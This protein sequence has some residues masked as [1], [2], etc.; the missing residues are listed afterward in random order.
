[1]IKTLSDLV[2]HPHFLEQDLD[3]REKAIRRFADLSG[4]DEDKADSLV[5]DYERRFLAV[6]GDDLQK[7]VNS[8]LINLEDRLSK[9]LINK[10]QY[11][12][13]RS[14]V[15]QIQK[16]GL[17]SRQQES[18]ALT[19]AGRVAEKFSFGD[20]DG[21]VEDVFGL[22]REVKN[23]VFSDESGTEQINIL[24]NEYS[25]LRKQRGLTHKDALDEISQ[26]K[27]AIRQTFDG[28]AVLLPDNQVV[29]KEDL[30]LQDKS[31]VK[32]ALAKS[33]IPKGRQ[34]LFLRDEFDS[35]QQQRAEQY[36]EALKSFFDQTNQLDRLPSVKETDLGYV[37]R[38]IEE[39]KSE[40]VVGGTIKRSG[41][42]LTNAA[43]SVITG[44]TSGSLLATGNEEKAREIS[45]ETSKSLLARTILSG[46]N[47]GSQLVADAI[48][49]LVYVLPA[50]KGAQVGGRAL[51]ALGGSAKLGARTG[52][53]VAAGLTGTAAD[54]PSALTT[55]GLS[56]KDA[57][58]SSIKSG[59]IEAIASFAGGGAGV[60][61]FLSREF[62]DTLATTVRKDLVRFGVD[63]SE[64]ALEEG[65]TEAAQFMFVE[66]ER[67]PNATTADL[68]EAAEKGA[69]IGSF[70]GAGS[71]AVSIGADKLSPAPKP[72]ES[73][74]ITD[75]TSDASLN[76]LKEQ[77]DANL[78]QKITNRN[79]QSD[80]LKTK[81]ED[82]PP[83]I[84][85]DDVAA[86]KGE[87]TDPETPSSSTP[88]GEGTLEEGSG[89]PV[90]EVTPAEPASTP[91]QT[92]PKDVEKEVLKVEETPVSSQETKADPVVEPESIP[93]EAE[94]TSKVDNAPVVEET[95]SPTDSKVT[96]DDGTNTPQVVTEESKVTPSPELPSNPASGEDGLTQGT[97]NPPFEGSTPSSRSE[98]TTAADIAR[99]AQSQPRG[100][101]DDLLDAV[102]AKNSPKAKQAP[103][104]PEQLKEQIAKRKQERDPQPDPLPD[105]VGDALDVVAEE[106]DAAVEG[107]TLTKD[108]AN[109]L[110]SLLNKV[111]T[112]AQA[113]KIRDAIKNDNFDLPAAKE[114]KGKS[115]KNA[116]D[117]FKDNIIND[118]G[119]GNALKADTLSSQQQIEVINEAVNESIGQE[120]ADQARGVI[121]S[122]LFPQVEMTLEKQGDRSELDSAEVSNLA[123]ARTLNLVH[124]KMKSGMTF[125]E[126][127]DSAIFSNG[128]TDD[129]SG[130]RD[131]IIKNAIKTIRRE[132]QKN[133][134]FKDSLQFDQSRQSRKSLFTKKG[135]R[136]K[137]NI[138]SE[139]KRT[140]F[141]TSG[142]EQHVLL[143]SPRGTQVEVVEPTNRLLKNMVDVI[144]DKT[145]AEV[146]FFA[147]NNPSEDDGFFIPN[148]NKVYIDINSQR[149]TALVVGHEVAHMLEVEK[150]EIFNTLVDSLA[151]SGVL[152]IGSPKYK[153]FLKRR[154]YQTDIHSAEFF[155]EYTSDML[156][157]AFED[158][159][160]LGELRSDINNDSV[161]QQ[162]IEA[163][164]VVFNKMLI[165]MRDV[166]ADLLPNSDENMFSAFN[167]SL[168]AAYT[169]SSVLNAGAFHSNPV[170]FRMQTVH[171]NHFRLVSQQM[172]AE[173]FAAPQANAFMELTQGDVR[174]SRKDNDEAHRKAEAAGDL[175]TGQELV[176]EA[177]KKSGYG[178][179]HRQRNPDFK[180]KKE[181]AQFVNGEEVS[182]SYGDYQFVT[183][184]LTEIPEWL[185]QMS[186][187]YF[188]DR[189]QV[190]PTDIVDAALAWDD[191]QFAS[192]VWQE[193]ENRGLAGEVVG[194]ETED[195]GVILDP[196]TAIED[197]TVKSADPFTYDDN[198]VLIPLSER[199]NP[200]SPDIR[201]SKKSKRIT[202]NQGAK[203][204]AGAFVAE[205]GPLRD[206]AA[207]VIGK[208]FGSEIQD[209]SSEELIRKVIKTFMGS[210]PEKIERNN[211]LI[212]EMK[213]SYKGEFDINTAEDAESLVATA[214]KFYMLGELPNIQDS[215]K[216][217]EL[218]GTIARS[219]I[220][221]KTPEK[222]TTLNRKIRSHAQG[223]S[224]T[225]NIGAD[226]AG[227]GWRYLAKLTDTILSAHKI[228]NQR[229]LGKDADKIKEELEGNSNEEVY[230]LM[231]E[232]SEQSALI[233]RSVES[234]KKQRRDNNRVVENL[235]AMLERMRGVVERSKKKQTQQEKNN[236]V[237]DEMIG[238]LRRVAKLTE[239]T[240]SNDIEFLLKEADEVSAIMETINFDEIQPIG[241]V[242]DAVTKVRKATQKNKEITEEVHDETDG[243]LEADDGDY[244]LTKKI[245]NLG[246]SIKNAKLNR[247]INAH[248][249]VYNTE[250]TRLRNGEVNIEGAIS[251]LQSTQEFS[252]ADVDKIRS[253]LETDIELRRVLKESIDEASDTKKIHERKL[254]QMRRRR[255]KGD[256]KLG[257]S[258]EDSLK[259]LISGEI[260]IDQAVAEIQQD[261][262]DALVNSIEDFL[263]EGIESA[264]ISEERKQER[265]KVIAER[266]KKRQAQV[267]RSNYIK[268]LLTRNR[269]T[270]EQFDKFLS[271]L[272]KLSDTERF[273]LQSFRDKLVEARSVDI[274]KEDLEA[275]KMSQEDY[276]KMVG[277]LQNVT[278]RER[279]GLF[280]FANDLVAEKAKEDA[281]LEALETELERKR[282][283]D[284][285]E[286]MKDLL[287]RNKFLPEKFL[288]M[289][290]KFDQLSPK[291][292]TELINFL[293][294]QA[295]SESIDVMKGLYETGNMTK[296]EF[297]KSVATL[298]TVTPAKRKTLFNFANKVEEK[299]AREEQ[300]IQDEKDTAERKAQNKRATRLKTLLTTG[301]IDEKFFADRVTE[302]DKLSDKEKSQLDTFLKKFEE[303]K[304]IDD[305]KA[306]LEGGEV[307]VREFKQQVNA[308]KS[309]TDKQRQALLDFADRA[310]NKA[311]ASLDSNLGEKFGSPMT[312][313]K[314]A[315]S[316]GVGA[317]ATQTLRAKTW[318]DMSP[319]EKVKALKG[320]K[321]LPASA[322][323]TPILQ[324][325]RDQLDIINNDVDSVRDGESDVMTEAIQTINTLVKESKVPPSV[326]LNNWLINRMREDPTFW[327][328]LPSRKIEVIREWIEQDLKNPAAAQIFAELSANGITD[329]SLNRIAEGA[330]ARFDK[331]ARQ[332]A[333]SRA[334]NLSNEL[335]KGKISLTT[336]MDG[337]YTGII[338]HTVS[339][340]AVI[341]KMLGN[342]FQISAK[343]LD[344]ITKNNA[345]VEK[346]IQE[347]LDPYTL[348]TGK[349]ALREIENVLTRELKGYG[350]SFARTIL[351]STVASILTTLSVVAGLPIVG[352]ASA[353]GFAFLVRGQAIFDS[354]STLS[355]SQR[356]SLLKDDIKDAFF[357][358][359]GLRDIADSS[360]QGLL[361]GEHAIGK[362]NL[363]DD[364][365]GHLDTSTPILYANILA[366]RSSLERMS[367]LDGSTPRATADTVA[368]LFL[369][370]IA[371]NTVVFNIMSGIANI[372]HT[373]ADKLFFSLE[374][375]EAVLKGHLSVAEYKHLLKMVRLK[376]ETNL[377]MMERIAPDQPA[378]SRRLDNQRMIREEVLDYLLNEHGFED[379][380]HAM[381]SAHLTTAAM[382]GD[383]SENMGL[384]TNISR[385]YNKAINKPL[386]GEERKTVAG[387]TKKAV[388][389]VFGLV[390][391]NF[392]SAATSTDMS[393]Y[394]TPIGFY[395]Y[396]IVKD[397]K[398]RI[399]KTDSP[400]HKRTLEGIQAYNSTSRQRKTNL[401][402]TISGSTVL[403][404]LMAQMMFEDD[405][406]KRLFD[407]DLEYPKDAKD[408]VR[409]KDEEDRRVYKLYVRVGN[410]RKGIDMGRG[411][412][413][414]LLAPFVIAKRLEQAKKAFTEEN[415]ID[416]V[417]SQALGLTLDFIALGS[418]FI[419]S[420]EDKLSRREYDNFLSKEITQQL[421]TLDI[422]PVGLSRDFDILARGAKFK[423]FDNAPWW[424]HM[425]TAQILGKADKFRA[426]STD[427]WGD[428]IVKGSRV[429]KLNNL[430]SPITFYDSDAGLTAKEKIGMDLINRAG[431]W[432]G[433]SQDP[434]TWYRKRIGNDIPLDVA[435]AHFKKLGYE[436]IADAHAHWSRLRGGIMREE[437]AERLPKS[438]EFRKHL[439][440]IENPE[441]S[442]D[443]E[444]EISKSA[445]QDAAF[446][447]IRRIPTEITGKLN[448]NK[449]FRYGGV[450]YNG[451][452]MEGLK[453]SAVTTE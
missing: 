316:F 330:I 92:D 368:N 358:A 331:A 275:G 325:I 54:L 201:S 192:E 22:A 18:N 94:P 93:I 306:D 222:N 394:F 149:S 313:L 174:S 371:L 355:K 216:R 198:G 278:E 263:S 90:S 397:I 170:A 424:A 55:E 374:A 200:D 80:D 230:S 370:L 246:K 213:K 203:E 304:I 199:F 9:G 362:S 166:V 142:A 16:D 284:R 293:D 79:L 395:K 212:E 407:I 12:E 164:Q 208:M 146:V 248:Q 215:N 48:G 136:F 387:V 280:K 398:S 219:D 37:Q 356:I 114:T 32:K 327:S 183:K 435:N 127:L 364:V 137:A 158:A 100:R 5:V 52:G 151:K 89:T 413:P 147:T 175:E 307:T 257:Y 318:S 301:K 438:E 179:R 36:T 309:V 210:T 251:N 177:S 240:E 122:S 354:S 14:M 101:A 150:P 442:N 388:Q 414:Q 88:T 188:G 159:A 289:I 211:E 421:T 6:N 204:E 42:A 300:K 184:K 359:Q 262:P 125:D 4:A 261:L 2:N 189:E 296:E 221:F 237:L 21:L 162:V 20:D 69:L 445:A 253:A 250:V 324:A 270:P 392:T 403:A 97:A 302:L 312:G 283:K 227:S 333:L 51:Q 449:Q 112:V 311:I 440:T 46:Q 243:E 233:K 58:I 129:G 295:E 168:K 412:L 53:A 447:I 404:A 406:D 264:R 405:E 133:T 294:K 336:L 131:G 71:S 169:L 33:N 372:F 1:M 202:I 291:E 308:L 369:S 268:D 299:L 315:R 110:Q 286:L 77:A 254:N 381:H 417:G 411:A 195:G 75:T 232:N 439:K 91:E 197:G 443:A 223:L 367:R 386:E 47:P 217:A 61:K 444:R 321:F 26:K 34:L 341:G 319:T 260:D 214:I 102:R 433:E 96:Q 288:G 121:A 290:E 65:L 423:T 348:S 231:R 72:V 383:N 384:F 361:F 180:N 13:G 430:A 305:L 427:S 153:A 187:D 181:N 82:T 346:L 7:E 352:G 292:K 450:I 120:Q 141:R 453:K 185:F 228:T 160:A 436:S 434:Q 366:L 428:P 128:R 134:E 145:G 399:A 143:N 320:S 50:G 67:N 410:Y 390:F 126:A 17:T 328:E 44:I 70:L 418:P 401:L 360:V 205:A 135:S 87:Q 124:H 391:R 38:I 24:F 245:K 255:E 209:I 85:P 448:G 408:A 314:I 43:E 310:Q 285:S 400:F 349:M 297:L 154:G 35:I 78:E 45:E 409:F 119:K 165:K 62:R 28:P 19:E 113:R 68:A 339:S 378:R 63:V 111:E 25:Q 98:G 343:G 350:R 382:T 396:H 167:D 31:E 186:E 190:N 347:G 196:F 156:G 229:E 431:W 99:G 377:E 116:V 332:L 452:D 138:A 104:T 11:L 218:V 393:L 277:Q 335:S 249:E 123:E 95:P 272:D 271:R 115:K 373:P 247:D 429:S 239:E 132:N 385:T 342:D 108:E 194:F 226:I 207:S 155:R 66:A 10:A 236:S 117:T 83:A 40:G 419:D 73:S 451:F 337:I 206:A 103:L 39:S 252:E 334:E 432:S 266:R 345:I 161:F 86:T 241:E 76:E 351:S 56:T 267:Q 365:N 29:L 323:T 279:A 380:K 15:A 287:T 274:A 415:L 74:E 322:K 3:G 105:D 244:F 157:R 426:I 303:S 84:D 106:I 422:T 60:E 344:T 281:R 191:L 282:Q 49:S 353:L 59:S 140:E 178:K 258:P 23:D 402:S 224:I 329:T 109:N 193:I 57:L 375:Q 148:S 139:E 256:P 363:D 269:I 64:E 326:G 379:A 163:L 259:K 446:E 171:D 420:I 242:A 107:G 338:D 234:L 220:H 376:S 317:F 235:L 425:P 30:I 357:S 172:K 41:A 238:K 273:K 416:A 225:G 27:E 441:G 130:I 182:D 298:K 152:K 118:D 176:N 8:S 144:G 276:L 340:D 389:L 437:F 265:L 81:I 173:G